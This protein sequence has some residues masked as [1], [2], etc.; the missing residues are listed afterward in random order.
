MGPLWSALRTRG[1]R[2]RTLIAVRVAIGAIALLVVALAADAVSERWAP[3]LAAVLATAVVAARALAVERERRVWTPLAVGLATAATGALA[4]G[5]PGDLVWLA[6]T[7]AIGVTVVGLMR[8]SFVRA[9]ASTWMDGVVATLTFAAPRGTRPRRAVQAP[10]ARRPRVRR[11]R[12]RDRGDVG[13]A[14]RRRWLLIGPRDARAGSSATR[15][16]DSVAGGGASPS[17][18]TR[19]GPPAWA[20]WPPR[21][22][23]RR[24]RPRAC[25]S[26]ARGPAARPPGSAPSRSASSPLDR[27]S[28][29]STASP[30]ASRSPRSGRAGP[31]D[32]D[33][34]RGPAA[35]RRAPRVPDRRAHRAAV[36]AATS[37]AGWTPCCARPRSR[38]SLRAADLRP[39]PLQGAQRHARPRRRRHAAAARRPA[40]DA[41]RWAAARCS[42]GWA[43]TS[44]RSCSRPAPTATPALRAGATVVDAIAQ[45]VR[46]RRAGAGR[47]RQRRR[48]AAT[49]STRPTDGELMRRADVAMYLAKGAGGGV[50]LYDPAATCTRATASRSASSC[51]PALDRGELDGR[52]YQPKADPQLGRVLGVEALVRWHHPSTA[53]WRRRT[54]CRSP[55]TRG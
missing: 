19:S 52:H 6:A 35:G 36:A 30:S 51:A 32:D 39:R 44:S 45:P 54:S 49:P 2:H 20:C 47:R 17:S 4:V 21:P 3:A 15:H 28:T 41:T 16:L 1:S 53:C 46:D 48:R 8:R 50:A 10:P 18:P 12:P 34:A 29:R 33:A 14:A 31:D 23:R 24:A 11:P 38:T 5:R 27:I 43:A 37:T 9:P 25:A 26:R 7:S 42:R 13:L 40:A 22:G 55:R